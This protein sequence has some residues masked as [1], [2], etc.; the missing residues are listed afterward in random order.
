[1]TIVGLKIEYLFNKIL[2]VV[3]KNILTTNVDKPSKSNDFLTQRKQTFSLITLSFTLQSENV[4]QSLI[5]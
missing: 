2:T 5:S 3:T 1:M 4:E